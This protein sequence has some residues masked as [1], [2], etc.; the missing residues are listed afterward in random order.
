MKDVRPA[1]K[2]F[3][4][5][6][7]KFLAIRHV[8][9]GKELWDF[10]G[11]MIEYGESPHEALKREVKEETTLDIEIHQPLGLWWFYH[12]EQKYQVVCST[13]RCTILQG[14]VD[15]TQNF[16]DDVDKYAWISKKEFLTDAYPVGDQSIKELISK[17]DVHV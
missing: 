4:E 6:N 1:V 13:F 2:A 8:L 17:I 14:N 7:G 11:G 12:E 15:I 3:I 5:Q 10:P 16:E 9:N